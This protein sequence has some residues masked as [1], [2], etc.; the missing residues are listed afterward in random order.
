MSMSKFS[1]SNPSA[2]FLS[3]STPIMNQWESGNLSFEETLIQLDILRREALEAQHYANQA[4]IEIMIGVMYGFR[5]EMDTAVQQF[6]AARLLFEEAGNKE[7][8]LLCDTNIA[9][10]YQ[11]KGNLVR[12]RQ[13]Y[14]TA[15]LE[16]KRIKSLRV[17]AIAI[18]KIG[19][20]AL[21]QGA[22]EQA[23]PALEEGEAL[24]QQS[25]QRERILGLLCEIYRDLVR[26]YLMQD[27]PD[28]AWEAARKGLRTAQENGERVNRG[29]ANRAIGELLTAL[30]KPPDD[31][32]DGFST[33]TDV[34]FQAAITYFSEM[35]ADLDL[36]QTLRAHGE[37]MAKRGQAV[38]GARKVQQAARIYE[39]LGLMNEAAKA[40]ELQG[41]ILIDRHQD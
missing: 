20:I 27:Q 22:V 17:Q 2:D 13:I 16:A 1:R 23:I 37:S 31:L 5:G 14:N 34:Y 28:R 12:A 3:R 24:A 38:S 19:S 26:A 9:E 21:L 30:G 35:K 25:D 40:T 36:A 18:S 10:A 33:D 32:E 39:R 41:K 11:N 7:R 6:R 8:V 29:R 15:Y 4:Q